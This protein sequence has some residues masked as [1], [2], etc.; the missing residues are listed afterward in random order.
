MALVQTNVSSSHSLPEV[1]YDPCV[2]VRIDAVTRI[3]NEAH[4]RSLQAAEYAAMAQSKE[5]AV[6]KT[7]SKH[8]TVLQ[9]L[10]QKQLASKRGRVFQHRVQMIAEKL[11]RAQQRTE[12]AKASAVAAKRD[13]DQTEERGRIACLKITGHYD[14]QDEIGGGGGAK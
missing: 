9:R 10:T 7:L 11:E 12:H 5:D 2:A 1:T 4:L 13:A 8:Q 3:V 6:G 14:E